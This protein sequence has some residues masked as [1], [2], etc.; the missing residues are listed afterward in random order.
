MHR[1]ISEDEVKEFM[2]RCGP[3]TKIYFG[4]DSSVIKVNKKKFFDVTVVLVIHIDGKHGCKVFAEYS[5]WADNDHNAGRPFSRMMKE[6]ECVTEIHERLKHLFDDYEIAIHLDISTKK[7]AG[8]NVA[9][10]AARGYVK[11]MTQVEPQMKPLAFC[12][13]FAADRAQDLGL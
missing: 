2:K 6:A 7:T 4:A 11:A 5:R 1:K 8:S 3:D 10:E 9:M 12:A 13:S